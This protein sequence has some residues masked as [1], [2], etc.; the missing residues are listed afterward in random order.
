M[1]DH[2]TGTLKV[3]FKKE[4]EEAKIHDPF[5]GHNCLMNKNAEFY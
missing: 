2:K 4:E 1:I 5:I 3:V